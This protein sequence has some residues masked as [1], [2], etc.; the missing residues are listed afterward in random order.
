MC[1][2]GVEQAKNVIDDFLEDGG[3]EFVRDGIAVARGEHELRVA[4]DSQMSGDGG[5]GNREAIGDVARG[6]G[7]FPKEREDVP[8][9]GV[10]KGAKEGVRCGHT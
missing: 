7:A 9:R 4:K 6:H 3:V 2:S 10:G 8:A 1:T 5:P